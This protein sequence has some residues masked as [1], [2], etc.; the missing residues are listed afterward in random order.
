MNHI[1][2]YVLF[3]SAADADVL[4]S[5]SKDES[6]SK[7]EPEREPSSDD[8]LSTSG[9]EDGETTTAQDKQIVKKALR[10]RKLASYRSVFNTY[11]YIVKKLLKKID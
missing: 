9:D 2:S 8:S 7:V 10:A 5:D 3:K 4:F 11:I 6:D 1:K